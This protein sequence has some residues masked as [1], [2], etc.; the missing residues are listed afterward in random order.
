MRFTVMF[1][2]AAAVFITPAV[3]A[4]CADIGEAIK[5]ARIKQSAAATDIDLSEQRLSEF[6]NAKSPLDVRRIAVL[7]EKNPSF[8]PALIGVLAARHGLSIVPRDVA[9][10]VDGVDALLRARRPRMAKASLATCTADTR[11]VS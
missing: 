4:L 1:L 7:G 9:H 5:R 6:V 3:I 10:L 8:W 11:R 2:P